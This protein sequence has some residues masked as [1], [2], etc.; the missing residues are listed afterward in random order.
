M[1]LPKIEIQ[2]MSF[3]DRIAL[4]SVYTD[5][6]TPVLY[7]CV[8]EEKLAWVQLERVINA[9]LEACKSLS[10]DK[11]EIKSPLQLIFSKYAKVYLASNPHI[12]PFYTEK[13]DIR[14]L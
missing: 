10:S 12:K 7:A 5:T 1:K 4:V 11:L 8:N 9:T 3:G 2:Q 6:R 14:D 13:G